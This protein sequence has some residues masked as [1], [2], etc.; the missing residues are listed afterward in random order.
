MKETENKIIEIVDALRPFIINDG[1][2]IEF[3]KY[4]NN[5]VYIQ[6][7]GACADCEMMDLTLKDGIEAA[8]KEEVPEVKEVIN[9]NSLS[10]LDNL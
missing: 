4:E 5:I 6:M 2:N 10:A 3:V 8:I 1:G 9:I 7:M